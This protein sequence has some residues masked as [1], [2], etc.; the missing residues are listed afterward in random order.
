MLDILFIQNYYEHMI[1]IMQLS[2]VL[3]QHGFTTDVTLGT[4][5]SIIRA[6]V[7][8][9]PGVIGFY[10]TTGIHHKYVAAAA[11]IKKILGDQILTVF[12]GPHPTF[13]PGMIREAGLLPVFVFSA[14][15]FQ[16]T[17]R[18][19]MTFLSSALR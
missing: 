10:C 6:A 11:E 16:A 4:E 3:K 15:S 12:G 18:I 7:E 8:K 2:A 14:I 19:Q 17:A 13:V 5:E 1:S 9:R